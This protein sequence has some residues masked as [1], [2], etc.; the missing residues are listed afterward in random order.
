MDRI[1]ADVV[2]VFHTAAGIL[3]AGDV[4]PDG[5]WIH[6]RYL[7]DPVVE[8]RTPAGNASVEDWQDFLMEQDI[9]F[10]EDARRDELKEIWHSR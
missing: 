8:P 2:G 1:R 10:P 4:V 9:E 3:K 7:D 6:G 5:V